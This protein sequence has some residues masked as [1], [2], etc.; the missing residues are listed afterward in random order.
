M[1]KKDFYSTS[2]IAKL[3]HVHRNTIILA[4]RK[5]DL[6]ASTTPGGHNRINHEECVRVAKERGLPVLAF[7]GD[8]DGVGTGVESPAVVPSET[9]GRKKVLIVDDDD[10]VHKLVKK[11]LDPN[12]FEVET[13]SSGYDAGF[14]TSAFR[15]HLILLDVMLGDIDGGEVYTMLKENEFTRHIQILVITSIADDE[16]IRQMFVDDVPVLKKPFRLKEVADR[17]HEML[18]ISRSGVAS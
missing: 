7:P 3:C 5:G 17:V 13:A 4:I 11:A 8:E 12:L 10:A 14:K 16:K 18:G 15:P 9:G 2:E 6:R 1:K